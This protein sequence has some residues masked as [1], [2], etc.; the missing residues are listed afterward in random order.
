MK[1][2]LSAYGKT[3]VP[4]DVLVVDHALPEP[5]EG[6]GLAVS[7]LSPRRPCAVRSRPAPEVSLIRGTTAPKLTWAGGAMSAHLDVS[8]TVSPSLYLGRLEGSAAVAEHSHPG[9]WEILA[10]VDAAGT[11]TLD[12]QPARLGPKQIVVVA[13]GTKHSWTPDPGSTLVAIQLYSPPGPEQ[14]FRA[15]ADAGL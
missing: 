4:G 8:K 12:G 1:G 10:A 5:L 6:S 13:P 7:A 11:F 15:L 3:L 14:R 9:S 2:S